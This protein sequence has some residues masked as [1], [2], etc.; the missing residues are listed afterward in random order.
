[1]DTATLESLESQLQT[2]YQD[3]E[4]LENQIGASSAEEVLGMIRNLESQLCDMYNTYGGRR[5]AD[6][7]PTVEMLKTI[8]EL[9]DQLQDHYGR[10]TIIFE[11]IDDKPSLR[12]T[13]NN[14]TEGD[15]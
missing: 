3:R 9:K 14:T 13:W 5:S 10:P 1:M 11:V 2:L 15:A 7:G 12:A 6:S 8:D 4:A